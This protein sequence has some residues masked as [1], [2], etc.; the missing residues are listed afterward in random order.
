MRIISKDGKR[1][2]GKE[3][4][5]AIKKKLKEEDPIIVNATKDE[6][7]EEL[8][9]MDPPDAYDE[10]RTVSKDVAVSNKMLLELMEEHKAVIEHCDEFEKALNEFKEAGFY[11]TKEINDTFN[12]FFVFFDEEVLKHNRKEERGLFPVLHE[13]ML[14]TG[15]HSEGENPHTPVDLME[16]DHVKFVQL[17]T[18]SFNLLGLAMRLKD[19]EARGITFD[20]AYNNGKELVEM[21]RLHIFREDNT[22]FPIAQNILT[23]EDFSLLNA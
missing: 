10:K 2:D 7:M 20:L 3:S 8:S 17:A 15:E 13:R 9:P 16:D 5:A 1:I 23:K 12:K 6:D 18:L 11:I 19:N 4:T 22:L 21:L 14:E